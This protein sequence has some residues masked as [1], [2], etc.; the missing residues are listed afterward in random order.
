MENN[1]KYIGKIVEILV[2]KVD[3]R[4]IY[5]KT[6]SFKNV[7][8]DIITADSIVPLGLCDQNAKRLHRAK[9]TM[10]PANCESLVGKFVKIKITQADAWGLE[11]EILE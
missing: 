11:G 6:K 1:E 8:I 2:D 4:F 9:A 10:E 3:N 7:R 5:G